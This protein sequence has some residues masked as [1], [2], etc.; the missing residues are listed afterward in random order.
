MDNQDNKPKNSNQ[1][2]DKCSP[3]LTKEQIEDL[4]KKKD[5]KSN[6][7]IKK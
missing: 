2:K 5:A 4:R 1:D 3:V 6:E 7:I